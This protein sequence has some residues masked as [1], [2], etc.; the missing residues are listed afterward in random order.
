MPQLS[1]TVFANA[2]QHPAPAGRITMLDT[3]PLPYKIV[4]EAADARR[5][6]QT[7]LYSNILQT[8]YG[9]GI[10]DVSWLEARETA[11]GQFILTYNSYDDH[12]VTGQEHYQAP[13]QPD[14]SQPRS[15]F[16]RNEVIKAFA[17]FERTNSRN[18][19]SAVSRTQP[20]QDLSL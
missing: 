17:E 10:K 8:S 12:A 11:S 20:F 16:T 2:V 3:G 7:R 19:S 1:R 9:S 18:Y 5:E 13:Y 14:A 15:L 6:G 4:A